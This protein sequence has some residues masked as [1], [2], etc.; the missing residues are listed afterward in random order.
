MRET[1][2]LSKRKSSE[3]VISYNFL[4]VIEGGILQNLTLSALRSL[5]LALLH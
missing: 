1:K 4:E 2:F 5:A 3:H